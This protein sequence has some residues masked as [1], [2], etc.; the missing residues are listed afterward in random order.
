MHGCVVG[1]Y[2]NANLSMGLYGFPVSDQYTVDS[3][4]RNDFQGGYIVGIN[5]L[6][7]CS[8]F[9]AGLDF[10]GSW[11]SD[12]GFLTMLQDSLNVTGTYGGTAGT[13]SGSISGNSV[14]LSWQDGSGQGLASFTLAADGKS[15]MGTYAKQ[16]A[17]ANS[18]WNGTR[19]A[20]G[21]AIF[22]T[23]SRIDFGAVTAHQSKTLN[24]VATA[25][26]DSPVSIMQFS[27]DN[28][29]F[30]VNIGG[31]A[32]QAGASTTL[33]IRFTPATSGAVS[34]T[35]TITTSD[36]ARPTATIKL[37]GTGQ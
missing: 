13:V 31:F 5:G 23:P 18:Q 20:G 29:A 1:A 22:F 10:T 21:S 27:S 2:T 12:R 7:S 34:A 25:A 4:Y 30:Q 26:A 8:S 28:P 16:G 11:T 24:V 3:G 6:N 19:A 33:P 36:P 14:S 17:G 37:T 15:F 32:I 35:L 9:P